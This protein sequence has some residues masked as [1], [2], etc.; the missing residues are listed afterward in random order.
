LALFNFGTFLECYEDE[1]H[2]F[3]P[4]FCSPFGPFMGVSVM[5]V[6]TEVV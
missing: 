6:V 1:S 4:V 2:L 3:L 5:V